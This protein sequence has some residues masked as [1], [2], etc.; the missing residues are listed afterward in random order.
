[1]TQP[2]AAPV[3]IF[4]VDDDPVYRR[5]LVHTFGQ[6]ANVE[7]VGAVGGLELAKQRIGERPIDLLTLD[8]VLHQ[9]SGLT[10]LPW[11]RQ[12]FP[13]VVTVLLTAGTA[14]EASQAVDALLLGISTLVIK[15]SGADA[16][17]KLHAALQE[18]VGGM[19]PAQGT[20][21]VTDAALRPAAAG[22]RRELVA[23]GASTGGPPVLIKFL[24]NL[25]ATFQLPIL[26]T[27]HMS[28]VHLPY[29]AELMARESGRP[30]HLAL[31]GDAVVPG[32]VYL[33][34]GAAHMT[35]Q[36][37]DTTLHI[38]L[39]EGPEEHYCRPAVDPLFRSVARVCGAACVAVVMSGMGTDGA[40]GA[41]DLRRKGAPVVVQDKETSVVWGMPGAVV[42]AHAASEIV[43]GSE[44]AAA[45]L[46]WVPSTGAAKREAPAP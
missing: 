44:L 28:A 36:R 27:Q 32:C 15:P 25:P 4:I 34:A 46:R 19:R 12:N 17:A 41:V 35:V 26:V 1:M 7:V 31:Q 18:I 14:R 20:G 45:V 40:R 33:A 13:R 24:R 6:I 16:P 38:A 11:L 39:D 8:V 37:S 2:N 43:P 22:Q 29:F 30:V 21:Q 42:A 3:R 5:I 10:L 9:E 23:V